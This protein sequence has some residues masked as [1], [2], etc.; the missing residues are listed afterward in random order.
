MKVLARLSLSP[1]GEN[2]NRHDQRTDEVEDEA[3]I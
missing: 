2:K 1:E 3:G